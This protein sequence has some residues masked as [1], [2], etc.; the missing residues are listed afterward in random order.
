MKSHII[1]ILQCLLVAVASAQ[2]APNHFVVGSWGISPDYIAPTDEGADTIHTVWPVFGTWND[3]TAPAPLP[4][5]IRF[6]LPRQR[7]LQA[8]DLGLNT[9][10]VRFDHHRIV[11]TENP[12]G[13]N[14]VAEVCAMADAENLDVCVEDMEV[15][16]RLLGER[17]MLHPESGYDFY[18]RGD[19]EPVLDTRLDDHPMIATK[20][21]RTLLQRDGV[22]AVVIEPG[23]GEISTPS[24][25]R[26]QELSAPTTAN[27]VSG[28]YQLS[29]I[30]K[31]Y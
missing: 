30:V 8:S 6:I 16:N 1:L 31:D 22:N 5:S 11:R 18:S 9:I 20:A 4:D 17:I 27:P 10:Y 26:I 28:S 15:G 14:A 12:L 7:L 24:F 19:Y 23:M 25:A 29:V 2:E 21:S 3:L 13:I